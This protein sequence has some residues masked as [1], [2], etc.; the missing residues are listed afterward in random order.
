MNIE[1]KFN[2]NMETSVNAFNSVYPSYEDK[3]NFLKL[4]NNQNKDFIEQHEHKDKLLLAMNLLV[5]NAREAETRKLQQQFIMPILVPL[6]QHESVEKVA[7]SF[8]NNPKN[9]TI[10]CITA[11]SFKFEDSIKGHAETHHKNI[12]DVLEKYTSE[13]S[14]L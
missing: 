1:Q 9:F 11:L 10:F 2:E 12:I 4:L 5:E 6:F 13:L 7:E 3:I 8:K 14:N